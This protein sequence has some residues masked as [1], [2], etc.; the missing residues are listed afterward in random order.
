MRKLIAAAALGLGLVAAGLYVGRDSSTTPAAP[1]DY[2]A[3]EALREDHM[4]KLVFHPVAQPVSATPF[5]DETGGQMSLADYKGQHVVLNFWAT[6]CAPCRKEMPSL[7]NLQAAM[8][9]DALQVVTVATGRNPPEAIDRFFTETGI[10]GLPKFRD[11]TSA[12]ARDMAVAGLPITVILNP[13]GQE[14]ARLR[15]DAYWDTDSAK[16]ILAALLAL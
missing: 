7:A 5:E 14:I 3:I 2:S 12:L 16:A 10:E 13:E 6:W 15:G 9:G 1:V 8:G 4:R 11:P